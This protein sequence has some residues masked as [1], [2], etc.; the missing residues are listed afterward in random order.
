MQ[1]EE[2]M[3]PSLTILFSCVLLTH[4]SQENFG[5]SQNIDSL[6]SRKQCT[7]GTGRGP[8]TASRCITCHIPSDDFPA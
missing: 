4:P 5:S 7:A 6:L 8:V 3:F 1:L 2:K